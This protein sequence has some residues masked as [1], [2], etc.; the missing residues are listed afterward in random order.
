MELL[1]DWGDSSGVPGC[2]VIARGNFA[3]CLGLCLLWGSWTALRQAPSL[4]RTPYWRPWSSR[5]RPSPSSPPGPTPSP[6]PR[7]CPAAVLRR[8]RPQRIPSNPWVSR[9]ADCPQGQRWGAAHLSVPWLREA[10]EALFTRGASD[11][12]AIGH[13][14]GMGDC[15]SPKFSPGVTQSVKY[16]RFRILCVRSPYL[17]RIPMSAWTCGVWV[18]DFVGIK[19]FRHK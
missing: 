15:L 11:P 16:N 18:C 14:S 9:A 10:H 4:A 12:R 1:G 8:R 5:R 13:T 17:Y 2:A 6:S 19:T 7:S 3:L